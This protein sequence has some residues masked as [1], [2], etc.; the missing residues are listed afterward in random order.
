MRILHSSD[1]HGD[2]GNLLSHLGQSD[3]DLWVD[4]GDFFPNSTRGKAES[5]KPYQE[6]LFEKIQ[7]KLVRALGARTLICVGGNHDY[8]DLAELVRRAGGM[9]HNVSDGPIKYDGLTFSGFREI[10]YIQ[11][12]WNGEEHDLVPVVRAAMDTKPDVLVTH[13]PGGLLNGGPGGHW[14]IPYLHACLMYSE[15]QVRAH[16]F[17]HIHEAG[18]K[19]VTVAELMSS[20]AATG[21]NFLWL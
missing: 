16:L 21:H 1:L 14:G 19:V 17:G 18:Q 4:T 7:T 10:P 6:G 20:N 3:F 5:E 2:W 15:H 12:E 9:A 13:S 11:G 8:T